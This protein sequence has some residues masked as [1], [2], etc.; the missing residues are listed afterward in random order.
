MGVGV[1]VDVECEGSPG[2]TCERS[3]ACR[4]PLGLVR[5]RVRVRVRAGRVRVRVRV[6]VQPHVSPCES[7]P[8]PGP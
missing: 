4:R 7:A 3:I 8:P 5:V 2:A 1:D 6:T